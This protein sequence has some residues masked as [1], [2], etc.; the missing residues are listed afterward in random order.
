MGKRR[1]LTVAEEAAVV[2]CTLENQESGMAQDNLEVVA[3]LLGELME[4]V[5]QAGGALSGSTP[6]GSGS[7]SGGRSFLSLAEGGGGIQEED[8]DAFRTWIRDV[9]CKDSHD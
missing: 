6:P 7:S 4:V 8:F 2:R 1:L 3:H 9:L 5:D